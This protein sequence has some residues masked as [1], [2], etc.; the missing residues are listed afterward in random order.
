MKRPLTLEDLTRLQVPTDPT[1]SPDGRT[2]VYALRST[3]G[4][5]VGTGIRVTPGGSGEVGDHVP[6]HQETS[7]TGRGGAEDGSTAEEAA[8]SGEALPDA[9]RQ[10]LWIVGAAGFDDREARPLT[11]GRSDTSPRYS[12]SGRTLAFVRAA[13][14]QGQIYLIDMTGPNEPRKLTSLPLGAGDPVWSPDGARIAFTAPVDR[15]ASAGDDADAIDKRRSTAPQVST[16]LQYKSDG[17]GKLG[18]LRTQLHVVDVVTGACRQLTD[19]DGHL[20]SPSWHPT[21]SRIVVAGSLAD[22]GDVAGTSETYLVDPDGPERQTTLEST[23]FTGGVAAQAQWTPGG[24]DL[25]VVGRQAVEVGHLRLLRIHSDGELVADLTAPLDRN[26]MPGGPGYPGGLPQLASDGKTLLF[27]ARD[28]GCTGVYRVGLDGDPRPE[29]LLASGDRVVSGLSVAADAAVAA[30]VVADRTGYGEVVAVDTASGDARTLTRHTAT[31][32]PDVALVEATDRTFTIADGS[33]VHGFLLRPADAAGP[34]PLL[35]DIHGG[36]HN[37]WSPAPDLG[38]GYQQLLVAAGWTVLTLNPRASDGYGEAFYAATVGQ[39]G[40]GDQEDFLDPVRELIAD[41]TADPQ[42]IAVTG[43]SYGGYMTC[44]LTGHSDLFAAAIPAGVVADTVAML[45][46]DAGF[47]G[48]TMELGGTPWDNRALVAA[49][50]PYESVAA[51]TAPTLILHG[52]ADERC[53]STQAEQWFVA[54]RARGVP[55]EMV[56][57]PGASHLFILNGR[58]EH[59]RD[60]SQRIVDWLDRYAGEK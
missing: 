60:Y 8:D 40:A 25:L 28:R 13:A 15:A 34:T 36:P 49:Q 54:L 47:P 48:T 59:R 12:P 30:C 24:A 33:T 45:A 42:R 27:C 10:R 29:P 2:V 6:S 9:D 22:R 52:G 55:T 26:V 7:G 32:I 37:A 57:Y 20:G 46:S 41:G 35:L 5:E 56:L 58:P 11:T 51:V 50:S 23:G 21:G 14:G 53:P 44:W 31:S 39:W 3:R 4:D 18:T 1:I 19:I 16:A 43:Y 38:H 17:A